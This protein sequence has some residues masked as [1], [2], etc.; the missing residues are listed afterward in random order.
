MFHGTKIVKKSIGQLN[1]LTITFACVQNILKFLVYLKLL[2]FRRL[3]RNIRVTE[4]NFQ[5]CFVRF[6]YIQLICSLK[7][8]TPKFTTIDLLETNLTA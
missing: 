1:I 4:S 6:E 2:H 8:S 7:C 5:T 3:L